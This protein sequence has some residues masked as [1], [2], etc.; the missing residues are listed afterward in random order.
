M[1]YSMEPTAEAKYAAFEEK[2]KRTIFVDNLSPQVTE[3]VLKK[4]LD[5]FGTVES[6]SFIPNYLEAGNIPCCALVEMEN[7]EK[8]KKVISSITQFPFMMAGM[9]K[10]VRGRLAEAEMFDD[11]PV[12]PGRKI[13]CRWL[14]PSDPDFEVAKKLK[15]LTQK[16]AAE[17]S[18]LLKFSVMLLTSFV[19]IFG[20]LLLQQQL[21]REEKLHNQ[22]VETLKANFKKYE[23]IIGV[24]SDKTAQNLADHYGMRISDDS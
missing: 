23:M 6:V 19:V 20:V 12:K 3:P 18:F 11:R 13:H 1:H 21:N 9:P 8:A 4:A 17:A 10:P 5:Q 15:H 2:V 24:L 16:H 7:A 14:D 22:Q